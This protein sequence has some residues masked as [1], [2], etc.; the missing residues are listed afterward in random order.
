LAAKNASIREGRKIVFG[1]GKEREIFPVSIRNMRKMMKVM[2]GMDQNM[3]EM[4]NDTI[5]TLLSAV[6]IVL[7]TVDPKLISASKIALEKK[8]EL[9]TNG[10]EEEAEDVEDPL[11]DVLD[12]STMQA[13]LAAGMG[14]DPNF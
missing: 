5:D 6:R 14:T 1:D 7:E 12:I 9:I 13:V 3:N 2:G 4:D 8:N 10:K 11:E